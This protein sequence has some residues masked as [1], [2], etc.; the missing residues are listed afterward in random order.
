MSA[1]PTL[2][3]LMSAGVHFGHRS[4]RW[5]PKMKQFIFLKRNL[6]HIIDLK[7]TLKNI[8]LACKYLEHVA[9][10]GGEV[11]FVGTKRQARVVCQ[12]QARLSGMHFVI[13]RWLG[14]TLTNF[15]VIRS[16]LKRLEHL[17]NLET[18]GRM[19]VYSK[20]MQSSIVRAKGK[21]LKNLEG[22]R[23]MTKLPSVL[24][25]VDPGREKNAVAEA[26]RLRIPVIA[27]LDT[28]CDP[29]MADIPIPA[30]DDAMR[31]VAIIMDHL[32]KAVLEGVE[33]FKSHVGPIADLQ[34]PRVEARTIKRRP[35]GGRDD[36]GGDRRGNRP[37]GPRR[38]E[39]DR[40][41]TGQAP[42]QG[43]GQPRPPAA[44]SQPPAGQAKPSAAQAQ[45]PAVQAKPPAAQPQTP[46]A[47][48]TQPVVKQ[49][50]PPAAP[51][52]QA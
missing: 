20:K 22:I 25:V 41:P 23:K 19:K 21:M 37:S 34:A 6:V 46:A 29:E 50:E 49:P 40:R 10:R 36:R 13:E 30:N 42:A 18:S 27:V 31:S 9:S 15:S 1:I 38:T 24:V 43:D 7:K 35:Q 16:R 32:G 28:D 48:P 3:D 5:N 44:Q 45:T 11:L 51:G 17:E 14:G 39:G 52:G 33:K 8:I 12:N 4:S 47:Q 2:R 26:N